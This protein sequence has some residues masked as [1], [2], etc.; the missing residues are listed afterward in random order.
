MKLCSDL[1]DYLQLKSYK[2][3]LVNMFSNICMRCLKNKENITDKNR[4]YKDEKIFK[5]YLNITHLE[6]YVCKECVKIKSK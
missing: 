1:D 3:N 6:H 5:Q 4:K 2:Q